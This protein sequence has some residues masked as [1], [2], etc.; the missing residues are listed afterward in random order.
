V[1][2]EGNYCI[3]FGIGKFDV[4]PHNIQHE[5]AHWPRCAVGSAST[6]RKTNNESRIEYSKG[7]QFGFNNDEDQRSKVSI[8][9]P[10]TALS[11]HEC[12]A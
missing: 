2:N 5:L 9:R 3:Y 1:F 12:G 4:R 6:T 8:S 11:L 10:D 7:N